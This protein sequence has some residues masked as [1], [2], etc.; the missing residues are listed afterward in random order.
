MA[1]KA[2]TYLDGGTS[3]VWVVW[4]GR[5]EIEVWRAGRSVGPVA[6]LTMQDTLDGEEVVPDFAYPVA[7]V[8][9]DPLG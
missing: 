1:A 9:A 4:P 6:V 5:R 3:L 8:F 2:R 7:D